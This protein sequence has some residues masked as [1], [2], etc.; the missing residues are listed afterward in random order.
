LWSTESKLFKDDESRSS[1]C[2]A[3]RGGSK[4][5][6]TCLASLKTQ[7]TE[8]TLYFQLSNHFLLAVTC[9]LTVSFNFF[10]FSSFEHYSILLRG[11]TRW[12]ENDWLRECVSLMNLVNIEPVELHQK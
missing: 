7:E 10:L 6:N 4:D 9:D 3:L 12:L 1:I 5:E 11:K 8:V 2:S